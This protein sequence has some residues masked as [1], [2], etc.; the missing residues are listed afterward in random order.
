LVVKIALINP[1]N[2]YNKGDVSNRIGCVKALQKEFGGN[3]KIV[4]ESLTPSVDGKYFSRFGVDVVESVFSQ[5]EKN[6]SIYLIRLVKRMKSVLTLLSFALAFR[7]LGIGFDCK[8]KENVYFQRIL[9]SNLVISSPGGFLQDYDTFSSL[10]PNL[11]LI[12]IAQLLKKPVILYAQSIGPFRNSILRVLSRFVLNR[13]ELITLREE[14]SKGYLSKS[15]ITNPPII[16]TADA[17]FSS[18][19]H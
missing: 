3:V 14:I 5:S 11:Y 12:F 16:V 19:V 17:T 2:W 6:S 15:G 4:I 13:V 9:E 18:M 8:C 10:L 7:F 1:N